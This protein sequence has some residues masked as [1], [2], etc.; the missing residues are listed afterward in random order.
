MEE[1]GSEV[2]AQEFEEKGAMDHEEVLNMQP[3]QRR[4]T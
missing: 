2:K 3:L 4:R 1:K